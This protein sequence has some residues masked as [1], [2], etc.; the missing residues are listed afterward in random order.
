MQLMKSTCEGSRPSV[1]KLSP[2]LQRLALL[3]LKHLKYNALYIEDYMRQKKPQI[4]TVTMARLLMDWRTSQG[5]SRYEVA[6]STGMNINTVKRLEEGEGGVTFEDGFRYFVYAESHKSKPNLMRKFREAMASYQ[7]EQEQANVVSARQKQRRADDIRKDLERRKVESYTR[8]T[9]QK[10]MA[11]KLTSL[12]NE[13][14]AQTSKL[15]AE[16]Q[17]ARDQ[18]AA[19]QKEQ[20]ETAEKHSRELEEAKRLG[21]E[22]EQRK[23]ANMNW[24]ERIQKK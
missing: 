5:I 11:E 3:W 9:V 24:L 21:A 1:S 16:L 22:E 13:H 20:Q 14:D 2:I 12:T 19:M 8:Y 10:E 15:Q 18:I 23:F 17:S 4:Y 7:S 6:K